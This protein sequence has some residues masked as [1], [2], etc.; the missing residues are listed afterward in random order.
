MAAELPAEL[1]GQDPLVRRSDHADFQSNVA[2]AL[3]KRAGQKPRDLAEKLQ[4]HLAAVPWITEVALSGAGFLN[5]NVTDTAIATQLTQRSQ[6]SAL[7]VAESQS[8]QVV[9]VDYSAP[10]IAKEMHVGHLR[11]TIIGDSLARVLGFLGADVIRRNHLG[12][13][14][15]QFGMLIQYLDE[16]P[17]VA[18]HHDELEPGTSAVSALDELYKTARAAFEADPEF[19]DRSRQRV[20]A[21]QSGDPATI[22]R[23]EEI[24]AESEKSFHDIYDRLGV[25]LTSDDS[26]GE[27][28]YND[29]L[30]DVAAEL[31]DRGLAV[32]SDGALVVLSEE[33]TGPD[34]TPVPLMVRKRDGGYG[35]DTTDPAQRKVFVDRCMSNKGYSITE[36]RVCTANDRARGPFVVG[37]TTDNL[38]P[39]SSVRCFDPAA[40]GF[41]LT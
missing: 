5:L 29:L 4:P 25:L 24:V 41:V 34:D 20:V 33:V 38:P 18:W 28:T 30:D 13:W 26:A 27:S 17:E 21:L 16:H 37:G 22:A 2:L 39:L 12:D 32:D 7:G 11:T 14:G 8:G 31:T 35:Y 6:Q 10:N 15:T 3:A 19:A 23:W 1:A 9:T 36:G 40:G